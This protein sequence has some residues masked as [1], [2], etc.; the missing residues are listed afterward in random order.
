MQWMIPVEKPTKNMT[1]MTSSKPK[2]KAEVGPST[3]TN[4]ISANT[5]KLAACTQASGSS[6]VPKRRYRKTKVPREKV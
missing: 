1:S 4:S 3:K 5:R 6:I 2:G